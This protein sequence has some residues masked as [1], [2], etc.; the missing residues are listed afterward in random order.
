MIRIDEIYNNTFWPYL[1]KS[2]P[3]TKLIYCYPFGRTDP[4]SLVT[5]GK[6]EIGFNNYILFHDQ[7]PIHLNIH[8]STFERVKEYTAD[9]GGKF[10]QPTGYICT[11]ERDSDNVD[12]ICEKFNFNK[13]NAIKYIW[14][15]GNKDPVLQDLKK[16]AKFLEFAIAYEEKKN[17]KN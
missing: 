16:A 14:R 17:D 8:T 9:L 15:A 13:G 2:V 11:S 4:E 3:H 10:F 1:K 6:N 7:E 5:N 12:Y